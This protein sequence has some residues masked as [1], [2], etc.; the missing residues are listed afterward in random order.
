MGVS[1]VAKAIATSEEPHPNPDQDIGPGTG[2][3]ESD[4]HIRRTPP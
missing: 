1:D 2:G 4:R 3:D